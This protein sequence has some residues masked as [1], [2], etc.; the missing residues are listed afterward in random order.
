[1]VDTRGIVLE[2]NEELGLGPSANIILVDGIIKKGDMIVVAK[3]DAIVTKVKSLLLP[4]ALDEMRDPRDKF[5][6]VKEVISAAGLKITSPDLEDILPG[7]PMY[8][9]RNAERR[10]RLKQSSKQR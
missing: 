2:V 6:P 4:K 8:V 1:M 7:S 3:R 10:K 9:L 5:M